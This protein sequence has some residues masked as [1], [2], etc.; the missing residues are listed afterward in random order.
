[1]QP[2]PAHLPIFVFS[3]LLPTAI[4]QYWQECI[5]DPSKLRDTPAH[6]QKVKRVRELRK[7][8]YRLEAR[9]VDER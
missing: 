6:P 5:I 3:S 7:K 4:E 9:E 1:M 2:D 8:S